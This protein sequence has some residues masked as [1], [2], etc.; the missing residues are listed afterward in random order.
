MN[1]KKRTAAVKA[2]QENRDIRVFLITTGA[3]GVG[4]TLT[5]ANFVFL[6]EPGYNPMAEQQA[7][8]RV[9]RIGQ[10]RKVTVVRFIMRNTF[11][12]GVLAISHRKEQMVNMAMQSKMGSREE[13]KKQLDELLALFKKPKPTKE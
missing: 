10:R 12:E 2:F 5:A 1:S 6:M 4:I 3:G 13:R 7:I 9:H 11:E 8:D